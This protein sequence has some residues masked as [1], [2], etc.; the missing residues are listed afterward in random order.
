VAKQRKAAARMKK[1]GNVDDVASFLL[2]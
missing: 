1:N 2:S